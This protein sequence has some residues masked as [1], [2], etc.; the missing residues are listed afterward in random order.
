MCTEVT[1]AL[2]LQ[3]PSFTTFF[4]AFL[5]YLEYSTV[6][7]G[8]RLLGDQLEV[9]DLRQWRSIAG[10]GYHCRNINDISVNTDIRSSPLLRL[11]AAP[12]PDATPVAYTNALFQTESGICNYRTRR[13]C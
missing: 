8:R 13:H 6:D 11:L 12:A 7:C 1:E 4:F 3:C 10:G 9:S 2:G 5:R